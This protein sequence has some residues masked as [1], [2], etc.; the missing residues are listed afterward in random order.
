VTRRITVAV[1]ESDGFTHVRDL[2]ADAHR[3][4]LDD[5][6]DVGSWSFDVAVGHSDET[7]CT[8]NRIA[9]FS[10]DGTPVFSG[11][12]ENVEK[13]SAGPGRQSD[14][15]AVISGRGGLALLERA[16]VFPEQPLGLVSP[17]NRYFSFASKDYDDSGWVTTA[18]ELAGGFTSAKP[19]GWPNAGGAKWIGDSG[20]DTP[21][22]AAGHRWFRKSFTVTDTGDYRMAVAGD[23]LWEVYIDGD[24]V[25]RE[26]QV[27]A[28]NEAR[29]F[30]LPL[31]AGTHQLAA[32]LENLDRPA[33][34]ST[35][36][37]GFRFA[38]APIV[39][40]GG[41]NGWGTPILLSGG[42]WLL[43]TLADGPPGMNP[44]KVMDVLLNEAW[45]RSTV[46]PVFT[47]FTT[48]QDSN[49]DV[50]VVEP[51]VAFPVQTT[52]L[53]VVKHYVDEHACEFHMTPGLVLDAYPRRGTD[54]SSTV[55]LAY[56]VN[57]SRLR[58]T[59][60]APGPNR[61]LARDARGR[62]LLAENST[63]I[64]A[65]GG[66]EVGLDLGSA[67]SPAAV[68]RMTDAF[69]ADHSEPVEALTDVQVEEVAGAVPYV[70]WSPGDTVSAPNY[71]GSAADYRVIALAVTEDE[72]GR[73]IFTPELEPA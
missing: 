8:E 45:T 20:D 47:S 67:P 54:L 33:S 12:I 63:A 39:N 7:A 64:T 71:A 10:L 9:T 5:V 40:G 53:D 41:F 46:L 13:T 58:H 30:D 70:D 73:P 56:A 49:G 50:W 2:T 68:T 27:G 25:T 29:M 1:Y 31:D 19:E 48:S 44:G 4:W 26:D 72:A 55:T 17:P 14:R 42:T 37:T 52:Y 51:D 16:V 59:R 28:W 36:V 35:N 6:R 69:F 21:G 61:V 62:W 18:T 38:L 32:H 34:P 3:K 23:D 60:S 43:N 11:P 15:V 22:V 65:W 57:V 24:L 66:R